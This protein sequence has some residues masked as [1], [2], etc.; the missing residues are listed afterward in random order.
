MPRLMSLLKSEAKG[1]RKE[2]VVWGEVENHVYTL[3]GGFTA[4]CILILTSY[5]VAKMFNP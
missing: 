4:L 2:D 5:M 1:I 3:G